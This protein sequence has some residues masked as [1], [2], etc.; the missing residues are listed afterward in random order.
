MRRCRRSLFL[1]LLI[2]LLSFRALAAPLP[3]FESFASAAGNPEGWKVYRTDQIRVLRLREGGA[4]ACCLRDGELAALT[5]E[6]DRRSPEGTEGTEDTEAEEAPVR[7][8]LAALGCFEEGEIDGILGLPAGGSGTFSGITALKLSGRNRWGVCLCREQDFGEMR[9]IA[10]H[11]GVR[12]HRRWN[13][14]GMDVVR[15]VTPEAAAQTGLEACALC[16]GN[17]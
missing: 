3:D 5:V 9:F 14:S 12:I 15:M 16:G 11:G 10:V 17:G 1:I 8:A 2:L 6:T 7:M 4:L 13:C